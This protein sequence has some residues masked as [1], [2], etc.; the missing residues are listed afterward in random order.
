MNP[1]NY[2]I[3]I[4]VICSSKLGSNWAKEYYRAAFKLECLFIANHCL[5][6]VYLPLSL[7]LQ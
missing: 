6:V 2:K 4:I 3:I 5:T 7:D 1:V